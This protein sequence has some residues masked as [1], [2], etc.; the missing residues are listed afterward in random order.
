MIE[1]FDIEH[2]PTYETSKRMLSRVS[3][4]YGKSYV[5][6]WLFQVMGMEMEEARRYFEEL[7]LQAFPETAT[8]GLEYW[9]QR[10]GLPTEPNKNIESRRQAVVAKRNTRASMSPARVEFII[11]N[12]TGGK[13]VEAVEN[14]APYTFQVI[15][16]DTPG[17]SVDVDVV[18]ACIRKLKPSHQRFELGIKTPIHNEPLIFTG[19]FIN[20]MTTNLPMIC[21][22]EN[23][24]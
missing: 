12:L 18:T 6:K 10:Y 16:E 9:E 23:A 13:K 11:S 5:G 24:I 22:E 14:V 1:T 20:F 4:I 7:R 3:P 19:G 15:I 8:W 2:F 21:T 17:E